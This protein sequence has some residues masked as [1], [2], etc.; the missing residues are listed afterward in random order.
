MHIIPSGPISNG[1][2][3]IHRALLGPIYDGLMTAHHTIAPFDLFPTLRECLW[4]LV[5]L[6]L[7]PRGYE[8]LVINYR[9]DNSY[10]MG[11]RGDRLSH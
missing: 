10:F 5:T 6:M 4:T 2:V 9:Q 3:T 7:S 11:N 1:L 8:S